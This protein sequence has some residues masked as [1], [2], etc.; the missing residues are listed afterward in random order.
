MTTRRL[1]TMLLSGL[2]AAV[3]NVGP[4]TARDRTYDDA[5]AGSL[6]VTAAPEVWCLVDAGSLGLDDPLAVC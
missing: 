3:L 5:D 4:A 2:A 6:G 1:T